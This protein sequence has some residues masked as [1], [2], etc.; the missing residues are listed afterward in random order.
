MNRHLGHFRIAAG[1]RLHSALSAVSQRFYYHLCPGMDILHRS[2]DR[3]TG[4]QG[5]QASF[6][7]IYCYNDLHMSHLLKA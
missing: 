5:G 2:L 1:Q 3:V 4:L 6:K 7:R